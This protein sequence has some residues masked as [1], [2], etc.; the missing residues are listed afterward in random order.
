MHS[1]SYA[2]FNWNS[3]AKVSKNATII[4]PVGGLEAHGTH[5]P[6]DTDTRIPHALALEVAKRTNSLVLPPIE[7]GY[8]YT[9]RIFPGTV[10]L[11]SR[12]LYLLVRDIVGELVRN[13]FKKILFLNGHGGNGAVIRQALKEL[14]DELDFRACVVSWWEIKEIGANVGHADAIETSLYLHVNPKYKM[15]PVKIEKSKNYFGSV[16]PTPKNSFTPS[17]YA[18]DITNIS[19]ARG[20]KIAKIIINKLV[21]L[22]KNDLLLEEK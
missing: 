2:D 17:G 13:G 7:Y 21:A 10:S 19:R 3:L 9:L 8:T 20:A 14:S 18:G 5:L 15:P 1:T 6:L 16:I 12:T 4:I 11:R 22:V